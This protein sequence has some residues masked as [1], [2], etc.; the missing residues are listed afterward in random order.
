VVNNNLE[1][2]VIKDTMLTVVMPSF[3]KEKYIKEAIF[4]VINQKTSVAYK[5]IIADDCSTDNT[6]SIVEELRKEYPSK[7]ILLKS[8]T[9]QM[10]FKNIFRVYEK[11][12]SKYFC[13]LDA[14]D[15]WTD[16][17]FVQKSIN[18]LERH[19]DYSI[20]FSNSYKLLPNG[21]KSLWIESDLPY[22]DFCF[23]NLLSRKFIA[24]TTG[25]CV[26]RNIAFTKENLTKMR[27]KIDTVSEN[28]FR[29]DSFRTFS[30][31]HFGKARFANEICGTYRITEEGLWQGT[32]SFNHSVI[33]A[34]FYLDMFEYFDEKYFEFLLIANEHL[35]QGF[36]FLSNIANEDCPKQ[37]VD[38][39]LDLREKLY[40][41]KHV[42]IE[43]DIAASSFANSN[44][45]IRL[46]FFLYNKL[47]KKLERKG[48][49]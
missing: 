28:S 27:E 1:N 25:V 12:D 21:E 44:W 39:L 29:G 26:F 4:S 19:E 48:L 32:G 10:L 41:K 47:K 23:E 17:L 7:I 36:I 9:N 16:N 20:F 37:D 22:L 49:L 40:L 6:I 33:H 8:K 46:Y 38:Q 45:K 42:L 43:N 11:L 24:G 13:V 34:Q 5:L 30:H 31:L 15:F 14:D 2:K 18:F 35:R 3:N